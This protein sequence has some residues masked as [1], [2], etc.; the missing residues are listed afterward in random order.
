MSK[1][2]DSDAY[3]ENFDG[4]TWI[5]PIHGTNGLEWVP[6][7]KEG[8]INKDDLIESIRTVHAHKDQIPVKFQKRM[9]MKAIRDKLMQ[10]ILNRLPLTLIEKLC[11]ENS[12]I[13]NGS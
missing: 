4:V 9:K 11:K 10:K 13:E 12:N 6:L 8:D 2:K 1:D 5:K 3:I 7:K